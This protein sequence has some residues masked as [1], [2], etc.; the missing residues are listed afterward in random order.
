[1]TNFARPENEG[2]LVERPREIVNG[3]ELGIVEDGTP[4]GPAF[5][6]STLFPPLTFLCLPADTARARSLRSD[7]ESLGS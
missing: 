5:Q 3:G 4:R 1:M 6:L 7:G 2:G